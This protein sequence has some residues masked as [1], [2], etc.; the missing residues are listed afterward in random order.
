MCQYSV[1]YESILYHGYLVC[2]LASSI[3][4]VIEV[5]DN[6]YNLLFCLKRLTVRNAY[7][8]SF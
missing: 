3:D 4:G 6:A 8:R 1:S 5:V 7:F 2:R